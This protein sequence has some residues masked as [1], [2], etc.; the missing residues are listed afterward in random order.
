[1]DVLGIRIVSVPV[2]D[3]EV[4]KAFYGGVLGF[5][6]LDDEPMEPG[7]RWLRMGPAGGDTSLVFVT[8]FDSMAPGTSKGLV[9][10]V[11]DIEAAAAELEAHGVAIGDG[12]QVAPWGRYLTIDDPDGNGI[13]LQ[14]NPA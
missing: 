2:A 5:E 11:A 10:E 12:V 9:I 13:V 7:M 6:V 3:Q 8:W 14:Q 4:A 1:M